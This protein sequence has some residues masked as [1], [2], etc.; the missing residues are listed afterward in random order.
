MTKRRAVRQKLMDE[1]SF[2]EEESSLNFKDKELCDMVYDLSNAL[3]IAFGMIINVS[4]K[5]KF[6]S[7]SLK[8]VEDVV[9]RMR[10]V[11]GY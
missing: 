8:M 7:D 5:V 11:R 4:D 9:I 2:N 10:E 3:T 1:I 6:P